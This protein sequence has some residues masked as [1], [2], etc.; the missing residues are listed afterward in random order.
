MVVAQLVERSLPIPEVQ[1]SNPVIGKNLN[2]TMFTVNCFKKTKIKKKRPGMAHLK[3]ILQGKIEDFE[4][5]SKNWRRARW[6]LD[7]HHS[8]IIGKVL[9]SQ[10]LN[11][12]R[13]L[14]L[15]CKT[16]FILMRCS[17]MKILLPAAEIEKLFLHRMYTFKDFVA[18][19]VCIWFRLLSV[20]WS[21]NQWPWWPI[22]QIVLRVYVP[23]Q[24]NTRVSTCSLKYVWSRTE[25]EQNHWAVKNR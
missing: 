7:H 25:F 21:Q 8:P 13:W 15:S 24:F 2:W 19:F 4:S 9:Q 5:W 6:S 10:Q 3:N 20:F 23:T 11:S 16:S 22:C 1:G 17:P 12:G 14:S 18:Y